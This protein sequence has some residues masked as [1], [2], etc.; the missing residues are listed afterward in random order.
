VEGRPRSSNHRSSLAVLLGLA[1]VLAIPAAVA[2]AQQSPSINL[3]D[4]AWAIP[5]GFGLGLCALALA[6]LARARVQWTLGRAGGL[7]RVRAARWLAGIGIAIAVSAAIS[8]GFYEVL[9]R[10]EK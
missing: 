7:G 2:V 8:V 5:A 3:L 9:L 6:N 4:A 10:F 1:A